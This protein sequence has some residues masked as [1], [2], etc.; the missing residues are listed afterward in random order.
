MATHQAPPSLGFSRH[1]HWSGLPFPSPM[2]ESEKWKR[3]HSVVS[4][5]VRP[6]GL[7]P[8]RLLCPW[9]FPGKNAGV[10]S[11]SRPRN[12]TRKGTGGLLRHR[13]IPALR[14]NSLPTEA[15]VGLSASCS[16]CAPDTPATVAPAHACP[17][18]RVCRQ[19]VCQHFGALI[20]G[21]AY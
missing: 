7:Q 18:K 20:I 9:D 6:H 11:I 5:S 16:S 2:H 10:G 3:S 19:D 8:A 4:D 15:G 12:R 14:A 21:K 17:V 13:W 1:E